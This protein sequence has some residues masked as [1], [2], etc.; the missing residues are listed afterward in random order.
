METYITGTGQKIK[1]HDQ[2]K[3][4]GQFCCI[5]N[6]S[7]HCMKDSP[8]HW[9][10]DRKLMERICKHG[11]GHPDPDDLA[12]KERNNLPDSSGIHGCDGCCGDTNIEKVKTESVTQPKIDFCPTCGTALG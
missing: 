12:Y 3:C 8:T 1:V 2:S 6:P 5:H 4:K 11:V 10:D 7:D 9:R